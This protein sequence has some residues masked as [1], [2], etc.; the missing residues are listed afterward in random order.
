MPVVTAPAS[1]FTSGNSTSAPAY[2]FN[3]YPFPTPMRLNEYFNDFNTYLASDWL[4]TA[5]GG[6]TS[7][8]TA[9]NGGKLLATTGASSADIQGN[10]LTTKGFAFTTGSQVW[11]SINIQVDN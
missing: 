5:V 7:A 2:A 6:G 3:N 11:F 8:L 10:E 9:G 1:R 4:V